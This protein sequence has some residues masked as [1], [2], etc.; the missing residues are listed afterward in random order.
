MLRDNISSLKTFLGCGF[1]QVEFT[2]SQKYLV[3]NKKY[4]NES[5]EIY[6]VLLNYSELIKPKFIKCEKIRNVV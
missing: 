4:I 3:S 5:I 2:L 6:N 1:K